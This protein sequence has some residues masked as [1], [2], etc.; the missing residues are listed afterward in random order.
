MKKL[1]APYAEL[2][3]FTGLRPLEVTLLP[4]NAFKAYTLKQK[5]AGADIAHLS[6]GHINPPASLIDF[7][8]NKSKKM[9]V[10][11]T[12]EKKVEA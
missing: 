8:L 9:K 1:D 12:A 4:Q 10:V 2:E 5:A 3:S 11:A 7:L 6:P